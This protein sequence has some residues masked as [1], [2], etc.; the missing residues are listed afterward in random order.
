MNRK[1]FIHLRSPTPTAS[2]PSP[3]PTRPTIIQHCITFV[4]LFLGRAA[5]SKSGYKSSRRAQT[6]CQ[7]ELRLPGRRALTREKELRVGERLR[8]GKRMCVGERLCAGHQTCAGESSS[9]PG[10][11]HWTKLRS[12]SFWAGKRPVVHPMNS[13]VLKRAL[14]GRIKQ[15]AFLFEMSKRPKCP[16]F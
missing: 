15:K 5:P 4:G 9:R 10:I 12:I 14:S 3:S 13:A 6:T 2:P 8:A 16:C 1:F 11:R 7:G